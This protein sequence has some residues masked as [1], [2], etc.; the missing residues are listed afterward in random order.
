MAILLGLY[1]TWTRGL[2]IL[3]VGILGILMAF[4]HNV[5]SIGLYYLAPGLGELAIGL[6]SGPLVVLGSYYVQ[7]QRLDWAVFWVS[8]PIGLLVS[9]ILY[10]N[11]FPDYQ[12]DKAVGKQTLAVAL[13]RERAAWG[14]AATI[15]GA[16][17]VLLVGIIVGV[18]PYTLLL[19]LPTLM[20][21][22][23]SVRGMLRYHSQTPNLVPSLA[24]AIQL[25]LAFGILVCL[26]YI[27]AR[28]IT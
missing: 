1:L 9:A 27:V 20:L 10:G 17:V 22:L 28:L 8:I 19:V 5:P 6:G 15:L 14:Y 2:F 13:G 24:M 26:G 4:F 18:L 25:D 12:A 21:A 3:G 11:E 16:F 7:A 23:R